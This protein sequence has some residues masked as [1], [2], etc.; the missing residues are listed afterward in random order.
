LT[1]VVETA[2]MCSG[3]QQPAW[4]GQGVQHTSITTLFYMAVWHAT[5]KVTQASL[6]TDSRHMYAAQVWYACS[7]KSAS[8]LLIVAVRLDMH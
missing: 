7:P 6:V 1:I 2:A 3:V 4:L 8:P 5:S